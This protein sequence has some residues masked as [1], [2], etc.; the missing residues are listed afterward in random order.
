MDEFTELGRYKLYA[1][2]K[3]ENHVKYLYELLKQRK[4]NISHERLPP[5]EKHLAFVLEHPYRFWFVLERDQKRIGAVYINY[6]NSIGIDVDISQITYNVLMRLLLIVTS[7]LPEI[8]SIR[9]GYFFVNVSPVNLG[10]INWL[11]EGDAKPFQVS[12]R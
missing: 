1:V 6:D 8:K 5:Y 4:Y 10:M 12:Y 3:S 11:V 7:P 2:N 9:S